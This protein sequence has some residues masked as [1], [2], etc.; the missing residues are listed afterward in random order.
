MNFK[1]QKI[2]LYELKIDNFLDTKKNGF[3][4]FQ[5][6]LNK[7]DYF[8]NLNV[9]IVAFD[10]ILNQYQNQFNLDLVKSKYGSLNDFAKLVKTFNENKIKIAPIIN[11]EN[12]KQSFINWNNLLNLYNLA[13][14]DSQTK[15]YLTKLDPYLVNESFKKTTLNEISD[16][17]RYFESILDFYLKFNINAIILDNFEFLAFDN[18][19]DD[20]KINYIIDLYNLIKRKKPNLTVIFK[21]INNKIN[22]YKK[23]LDK[24]NKC[25]DYLYLTYISKIGNNSLTKMKYKNKSN[26]N[27]IFKFIN[28]FNKYSSVILCFGSDQNGR[29]IS[30]WGSEKSYFNESLRTFLLLLYSGNNSIGFYYGDEIGTLKADFDKKFDFNDE[31][32]NE[33]KRY[34]QSKNI[35]LDQYFL[36]HSLFNKWSSYT[37]MSWNRNKE[38]NINNLNLF[39]AINHKNNNVENQLKNRDSGLNFLIFL[40]NF[41]FLSKYK[42]FF[43]NNNFNVEYSSGIYKIKRNLEQAKIIFLINITNNHKKIIPLNDY[44]ILVSSYANKFYSEAPREL[45]PFESLIL[46]KEKN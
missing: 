15:H 26:Y 38:K 23:M 25:F 44:S 21:S 30:K 35:T 8:K 45:S 12:I 18:L 29:F 43:E 5:G 17:I 10:D 9:D 1:T 11:L 36:F 27:E 28:F 33:E 6:I 19:K 13:K 42:S 37:Q 22:L 20:K 14:N 16:F 24:E 46:F 4:D 40:N 34:F 2:I 31:N 32:Y 7:I 3:G 39:Y 41:C